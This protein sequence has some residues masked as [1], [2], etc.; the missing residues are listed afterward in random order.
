[1]SQSFL[2]ATAASAKVA[3]ISLGEG[4][5]NTE[6]PLLLELVTKAGLMPVL[7]GSEAY[8]FFAPSEQTLQQYK[9]ARPEVLKQLLSQHIVKGTLTT[10]DLKDGSELTSIN[11]STIKV[12]R[13][14]GAVIVNGMRVKEGDKLYTNGVWHQLNGCFTL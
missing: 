2:A 5:T 7:T 6:S 13:K 8:T 3:T 11:G 12:Y 4:L 1:M 14:K 10:S 9:E